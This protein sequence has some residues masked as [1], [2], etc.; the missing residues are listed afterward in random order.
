[1]SARSEVPR[2]LFLRG[3][4]LQGEARGVAP[5]VFESVKVA[6]VLAEDVH[7]HVA[8]IGDDPLAHGEAI[9]GHGFHAVIFFQAALEFIDERA[10]VRLGRAGGDDKKVG[11]RGDAAQVERDDV[12]GFF[13]VEDASAK[14]DEVFRIQGMLLGKVARAR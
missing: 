12:L 2:L 13:V 10:E 14:L 9:D 8:E 1:M 7:D 3:G 6:F 5:E 11:E 4:K